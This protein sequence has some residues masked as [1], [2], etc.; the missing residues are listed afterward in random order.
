M[1]ETNAVLDRGFRSRWPPASN[2]GVDGA[3]P[4]AAKP[5]GLILTSGLM[6]IW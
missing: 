2:D 6:P 4:L 3:I 5:S 1:F